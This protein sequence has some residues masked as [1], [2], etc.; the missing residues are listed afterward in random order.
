[1]END[2]KSEFSEG[3]VRLLRRFHT[4]RL[5][6]GLALSTPARVGTEQT[7]G[8]SESDLVRAIR[9]STQQNAARV[10]DQIISRNLDIQPTLTVRPGWPLRA[11]I[12]KDLVLRPWRDDGGSA[13]RETTRPDAGEDHDQRLAGIEPGARRLWGSLSRN[14]RPIR[15]GAG[16]DPRDA[17]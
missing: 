13:T 9:E 3:C 12:H 1:M 5:L 2:L 8:S 10:G 14:L 7:F 4:W 11:V 16:A 6:K 15:A 17:G